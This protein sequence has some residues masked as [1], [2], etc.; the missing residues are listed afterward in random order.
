MTEIA[1]PGMTPYA[2]EQESGLRCVPWQCPG[3]LPLR[4]GQHAM[5]TR[6]GHI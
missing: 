5:V 2:V 4:S 3:F 1:T 6:Y